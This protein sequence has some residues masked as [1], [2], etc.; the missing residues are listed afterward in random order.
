MTRRTKNTITEKKGINIVKILVEDNGSIF[1][2]ISTVDDIGH[3]ANI[4]FCEL[5]NDEYRPSGIEIKVQIK[6]GE[7]Y[8]NTNQAYIKGDK[9]H[10]EYWKKHILPTIGIVYNPKTKILYWTNISEYLEQQE[11]FDTYNIPCN[12]ILNET[13]FKNF[14]NECSNY[15]RNNKNRIDS[16][17]RLDALYSE[18]SEDACSALKT[19]FLYDRDSQVFWNVIISYLAICKDKF[20]LKMMVY[21]L[22]IA[23]GHQ[24]DVFWHKDN[25][26]TQS[27]KRW[28]TKK[29]NDIVDE[30]ILYKILSVI[31]EDEGIDRGTIGNYIILFIKEIKNKKE[32]LIKVFENTQ[33]EFY[34]RDIALMY[35]LSECSSDKALNWLQQN[36]D[37]L[38]NEQL[39]INLNIKKYPEFKQQFELYKD[40]IEKYDG[41]FLY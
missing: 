12:K 13:N 26:I 25:E 40:C 8:F 33:Y 36:L 3:D 27:I 24:G 21:Y 38:N 34:I 39:P 16:E 5:N 30:N 35:Y 28:L 2:E 29:F 4:E 11:E 19:L 22:S 6:S 9:N 7:S 14:V 18:N 10:F 37:W 41:I 32:L 31:N 20:V 15:C 17:L 23:I 1:R